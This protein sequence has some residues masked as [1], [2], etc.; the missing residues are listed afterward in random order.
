MSTR[1]ETPAETHSTQR[2]GTN[3]E[4]K[5]LRHTTKGKDSLPGSG[6]RLAVWLTL[7]CGIWALLLRGGLL[8]G[9]FWGIVWEG[10]FFLALSLASAW[11]LRGQL[12]NP[13]PR[14]GIYITYTMLGRLLLEVAF[15][16]VGMWLSREHIWGFTAVAISCLVVCLTWNVRLLRGALVRR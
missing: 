5:G 16:F 8:G 7:V 3:G 14:L 10:L 9:P 15:V 2:G 11:I 13:G 12:E 1:K 4:G 6:L